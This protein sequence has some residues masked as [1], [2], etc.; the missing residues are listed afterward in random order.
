MRLNKL[1]T[2]P[3]GTIFGPVHTTEPS[4]HKSLVVNRVVVGLFEEEEEGTSVASDEVQVEGEDPATLG[5]LP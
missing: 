2:C 1:W 4:G 5:P 3:Q